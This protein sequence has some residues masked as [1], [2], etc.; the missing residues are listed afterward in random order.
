ML[1]LTQ[2]VAAIP[3]QSRNV[4]VIGLVFKLGYKAR[5]RCCFFRDDRRNIHQDIR[6][7]GRA[8]LIGIQRYNP[9]TPSHRFRRSKRQRVVI[10]VNLEG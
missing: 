2:C 4:L 8:D 6:S 5:H 3:V 9:G 10:G 1:P 7:Y